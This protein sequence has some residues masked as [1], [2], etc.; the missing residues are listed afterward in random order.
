MTK[1]NQYKDSLNLPHTDF[2][3]RGNL[4]KRE[5]EMLKRWQKTDVYGQIR[6]AREGAKKFHMHDGPP[7]AN[8]EIHLGHAVNKILKDL[9]I[10]SKT[11]SGYDA[12]Y[13][14]GWDCHGLPI[15]LQVEKKQGKAGHKISPREFRQ[16]C[17]EY[18]TAQIDLQRQGFIR[19]GIFGEWNS[20]Y[21][22]MNPQFEAD[23]VRALGALV[24]RG[25]LQQGHKPV[26][27]C[28]DC[29][30]ALAEAEVE[31]EDKNSASIDVAFLACDSPAI[32]RGFGLESD[33]PV[34]FVI[35]TTTPW[36]LPAN[37]AVALNADLNYLLVELKD[38]RRIVLA[39]D[40]MQQAIERIFA[41]DIE[42]GA[43]LDSLATVL[44]NAAGSKFEHQ[45]LQHPFYAKKVPLILGEHV[46]TEAGT[47]AVHTAPAHGQDD[48]IIGQK[49]NL[50]VKNPVGGNGVYLPGTELVAN[51]HISKID[52][53]LF[54]LMEKNN[55]LLNKTVLNHS[56]PHCWRHNSPV[57]F[58]AT[59]QWFISMDKNK[60]RSTALDE[61]KKVKW[62]PSWGEARISKMI[63]TRPDWCISR[64]RNWGVPI[65]LFVH[66]TTG[67]LHPKSLDLFEPIAQLI[68][69]DGIEAWF[70]LEPQ[71]L[72]GKDAADYDKVSDT[73]DV[74]FDSGVTH[75]GVLLRRDYLDMPADLYL[76]GSDQHRG[77]FQS[78]LLTACGIYGHAP[79][80]QVMTHGFTVDEK[81][82]KMSK[83]LGNGI[84][85]QEIIGSLGADIL[86]LWVASADYS[87]EMTLS[88]EILKRMAD[89]YRRMRNTMRFLLAN[90][91][92]FEP[93]QN[94]LEPAQ[95]LAFDRWI[96]NA[97]HQ[98]Q[99][100]LKSYYEEYNFHAIYQE[101]QNFC[102]VELSG[103]YLDVIKDRQYTTMADSLPRRSCQSAMY[104]VLEALV[105]W[106]TPILSFTA[107]EAWQA[108]PG[109]RSESVFVQTWY[110]GLFA[111][112]QQEPLNAAFWND[113]ITLR[114]G[115]SHELEKLRKAGKIGS[116]LD[117]QVVI[118]ADDGVA[119]L[120]ALLEDELRFV[121]ITSDAFVVPLSPPPKNGWQVELSVGEAIIAVEPSLHQ[122]CVRCWHLRQDVGTD[123]THS[124]LCGR[125]I[126]NVSG[127]GE[128]RKYV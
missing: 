23:I 114:Q 96:V 81:G 50:P 59:Q 8:G 78:S 125:C 80:K 126:S 10:K 92:G 105:R 94:L 99:Q 44:A 113:I 85:P 12:P 3:M 60:L 17:R 14:P 89:A 101:V 121:L 67:E 111:F 42:Q 38:K 61:I 65:T 86:R 51:L 40:L 110:T 34:S 116:S 91:N 45:L 48:F 93:Q 106:I 21:L 18:A 33:A 82:R 9:V 5:P 7:Y 29:K 41:A 76:E 104:H 72:I 87:R 28:L 115:V 27:W 123:K 100:E 95:M 69:K 13:V 31:Y 117:A 74:W 66:K 118:H 58:R 26:H 57:I 79:Y 63:E 122:K 25:H 47:G 109:Q 90:L 75:R 32:H 77:W 107:D 15:E 4:A 49:Y 37:E 55:T 128:Q 64:Q 46:S 127:S 84:E 43:T 120:L 62:I 24:K 6:K 2:P 52:D 102:S 53:F 20:P 70:E 1:E 19:L 83:S 22:T 88:Q 11:L 30:S 103:I 71:Q 119:K 97:A 98:L 112:E 56:Y 54:E 124:Q 73:L 108:M 35:W 39:E 68:E 16:A 36:T